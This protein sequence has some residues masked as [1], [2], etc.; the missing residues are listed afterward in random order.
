[1]TVDSGHDWTGMM[2]SD[3]DGSLQISLLVHQLAAPS[4][5]WD[6]TEEGDKGGRGRI[7]YLILIKDRGK[8]GRRRRRWIRETWA[9]SLPP[10][11][12]YVFVIV[13]EALEDVEDESDQYDDLVVVDISGSDL[14]TEH[15]QRVVGLYFSF[16]LCQQPALTLMLDQTVLVNPAAMQGLADREETGANRQNIFCFGKY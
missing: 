12:R 11:H 14:Y 9:A 13:G 7:L 2:I 6:C 8:E 1:M 4:W 3:N 10:G 5:S 16:S 15:R